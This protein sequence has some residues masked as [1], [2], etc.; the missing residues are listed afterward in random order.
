MKRLKDEW[1]ADDSAAVYRRVYG[2]TCTIVNE[3]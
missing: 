3:D 1:R 2:D